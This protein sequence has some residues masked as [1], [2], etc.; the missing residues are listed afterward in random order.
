MGA[1]KANL[2]LISVIVIVL[3]AGAFFLYDAFY[4]SRSEEAPSSPPSAGEGE[5]T[6]EEEPSPPQSAIIIK[7][8]NTTIT[9]YKGLWLP[10]LEEVR[11]S[12]G[13]L[14]NIKLDGVNIVAI[15]VKICVDG[16]VT[17]CE[18]EDEIKD[19]I[20]EFHKHGLKT[21]LLLNPAHPDFGVDPYSTEATGKPLL[22][23]LTPLVLKWAEISEEY[24]VE[25]F[26]PVNEP[27]LLSYQDADAVSDWA[28]ELLP[29]LRKVYH[30]KVAFR[31]HKDPEGFAVYNLTGY[32]LL[33]FSGMAC[34][35]D[36]EEHPE[37]IARLINET[38][39]GLR[40]SYP[41]CSYVLFDM[42]AFTGPDH[43]WWEPI[44]PANMPD[45]MPELPPDFF[46]VSNESQAEFY[47]LFFNLTWN[48]VEG[49]FLPVYRGWGYR[50]KPAEQVIREWFHAEADVSEG[51]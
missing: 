35:K 16:N 51:K 11:A 26:A 49:F 45:F 5:E 24:G 39:S 8:P 29:K 12:L 3:V 48:D 33:V 44:A 42:G 50:G 7:P 2:V 22:D 20:S 34:T 28:Q 38:L 36:I 37:W 32:D 21:F 15:G 4:L 47:D 43:Y 19:A 31:V 9:K 23:K 25:V 27:Q 1:S 6:E 41:G 46:T 13:D 30:G 18:S 17:E 14:D 40:A 10:F